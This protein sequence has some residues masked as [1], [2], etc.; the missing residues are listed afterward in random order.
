ML[1]DTHC[2]LTM[3]IKDNFDSTIQEHDILAAQNIVTQAEQHGVGI[4]VDIGTNLQQSLNCIRL[5]QAIPQIYAVVGI[6]PNDITPNWVYDLAYLEKFLEQKQQNRIIGIGECGLDYHYP[7]FNHNLQEELFRKQIELALTYN[8]ALIIH[9]R[10]AQAGVLAILEDY[11]NSNLKGIIHCFSED[12]AFAH[13]AL[14]LGFVL[15]IG[16]TITYPKNHALRSVVQNIGLDHIVLET[17]APFLPPQIIRGKKNHPLYVHSIAEYIAQLLGTTVE[18][19]T[20]KTTANAQKVFG[21]TYMK[22]M[23]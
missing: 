12:Q 6:H 10:D 3:I 14:A 21:L 4:I 23:L 22:S 20:L 8:L 2:H 1:I 18:E 13:R 9:T 16:G 7:G 15:G 17:D 11:K 5:A 19:V